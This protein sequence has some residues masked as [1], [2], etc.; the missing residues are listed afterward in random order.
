MT[1]QDS[2]PFKEKRFIAV[3]VTANSFEIWKLDALLDI[4]TLDAKSLVIV[5]RALKIHSCRPSFDSSSPSDG[6][7]LST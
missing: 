1:L 2:C 7:I 3:S 5:L 4:G 6:Q